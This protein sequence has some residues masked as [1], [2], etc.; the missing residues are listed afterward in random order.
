MLFRSDSTSYQPSGNYITA[1]TG[2][3]SATGPGSAV[4]TLASVNPT[5]GTW[6]STT[7][8]PIITTD[9]KGRITNISTSTIYIPSDSLS[10]GGDVSG[11]GTTG[12]LVNLTLNNVNSNVYTTNTPLKFSVNAKGLV[13][14]ASL[15]TNTDLNTIYGYTPIGDAPSDGQTY[16]R[17]NGGW[18][19]VGTSAVTWGSITGLVANQ[20]DLITYLSTNYVP[21]TRNLTINGTTYDLSADRTWTVSGLPSQTG[22]A[23]E[24]L[25]T[26]GTTASWAALSGNIT[27]FTNN[28]NY[29]TLASL[30]GSTGISYNNTTG[31]I[32]N[33][34]PDQTV[35]FTNGTGISVTGTYPNFTI[36]NTSPSSGGTVTSVAALTLGTSGTDLNSSVEIG[37]AH[38]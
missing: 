33:S 5:F 31:V 19:T 26:D 14:S 22:H 15:I 35:A 25:T 18:V 9:I 30:S 21:Q 4:F 2:D 20:T 6:G 7:Q 36:T 23:G 32:T 11:F 38:V 10:F 34:A 29:I 8:V 24:W 12:T 37:R 13:T 28:A 1:L 17:K 3:G 16:G 27:Q